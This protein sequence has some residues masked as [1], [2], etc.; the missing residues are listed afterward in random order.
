MVGL[1]TN[2][3]VRYVVQDDAHQAAI[4]NRIFDKGISNTNKGFIPT[5]V[6]C[7]TVWVLSRGYKYRRESIRLTLDTLLHTET[8]E[9]EHRECVWKAYEDFCRSAADFVDCLV[10]HVNRKHGAQPTLTFDRDASRLEYFRLA[11]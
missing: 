2:I 10:G 9:F 3:I 4:A 6:L 7:E 8:L 5:A 1:D 11:Q